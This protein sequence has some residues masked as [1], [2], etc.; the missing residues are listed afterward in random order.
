MN[1][2]GDSI[3]VY[4]EGGGRSD[5]LRR[6]QR[7]AFARFFEKT[8]LGAMRRPRVVACGARASAF[9][10]FKTAMS[11]GKAAILLVDS[12]GTIAPENQLVSEPPT[13][14]RPWAHLQGRDG[15]TQPP[16]STDQDCHLM[17]QCMESWLIADWQAVGNYF[18][19]GFAPKHRPSGACEGVPKSEVYG[20]LKKAT[21]DC[22]PKGPYQKGRDSF[23]LLRLVDPELICAA[24]P[25]AR[26]CMVELEGRKP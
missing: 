19:N 20:A 9:D 17:T 6:E 22:K 11:Q 24:S 21:K 5:R 3:V 7:E 2:T 16:E 8:S 23:K 25:W 10:S 1:A 12:E 14:W 4:V 13:R 18:G 26:R 15:W